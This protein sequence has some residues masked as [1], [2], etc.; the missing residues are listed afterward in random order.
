M[1][2]KRPL[3]KSELALW[4]AATADVQPL[5][6]KPVGEKPPAP[7]PKANQAGAAPRSKTGHAPKLAKDK[8]PLPRPRGARP[9]DPTRPI[10]IDRRNWARLKRGQVDIE[11]TL[12]LHGRTQVEAHG[13]LN[14][15][16]TMAHAAGLRCVLIVTGKGGG[17]G[18]GILRQMV[19]RWLGEPTHRPYVVTFCPAQPRHGGDGALYV[20]LKRRRDGVGTR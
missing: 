13:A 1:R 5:A 2:N 17:E 18:R 9:L 8:P 11:R 3:A 4:R 20:L 10:D 15:F 19:P 7:E 6:D 14:R 16:L 12:D